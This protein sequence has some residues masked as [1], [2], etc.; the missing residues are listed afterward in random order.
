[1]A[2]LI[3]CYRGVDAVKQRQVYNLFVFYS[4]VFFSLCVLCC[5]FLLYDLFLQ[6]AHFIFKL[7]SVF[8][9]GRRQMFCIFGVLPL[10]SFTFFRHPHICSSPPFSYVV[11]VICII[12]TP[13]QV[14]A[15]HV[16]FPSR[17]RRRHLS[18]LVL[19]LECFVFAFICVNVVELFVAC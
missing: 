13:F 19:C 14:V 16:F 15:F 5:C 18:L 1:M 6:A 3:C 17:G 11:I 12:L 7:L 8:C 10:L 4:D 2:Y 9:M